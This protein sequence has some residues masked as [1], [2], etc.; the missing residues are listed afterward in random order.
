MKHGI[1]ALLAAGAVVA[2]AEEP[3]APVAPPPDAAVQPETPAGQ[4]SNRQAE[5]QRLL[6]QNRQKIEEL[7]QRM[8]Q[9]FPGLTVMAPGQPCYFI[10]IIRPLMPE[11]QRQGFG[12][13]PLQ[14]RVNAVQRGPDCSNGGQLA[15]LVPTDRTE[16]SQPQPGPGLTPV[17]TTAPAADDR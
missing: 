16:G 9:Q 4:P 7:R 2:G 13:V 14:S 5:I 3:Q 12:L 17:R 8:P 1:I 10:R 15:P 11:S 6:E